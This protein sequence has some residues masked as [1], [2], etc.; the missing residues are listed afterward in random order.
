MK[1]QL[2]KIQTFALGGI[3]AII[4]LFVGDIFSSTDKY[5]HIDYRTNKP[6]MKE[7]A[8]A[9]P[10]AEDLPENY[11]IVELNNGMFVPQYKEYRRTARN[12]ICDI[13]DKEMFKCIRFGEAASGRQFDCRPQAVDMIWEYHR[14][15]Q[16]NS[17]KAK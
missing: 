2:T 3:F 6:H 7:V 8:T 13:P 9:V 10:D 4:L 12:I 14:I 1:I 5:E 17:P 16:L 15:T 11:Q